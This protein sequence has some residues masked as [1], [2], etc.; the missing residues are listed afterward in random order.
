VELSGA[1]LK[2]A[3]CRTESGGPEDTGC[4][5]LLVPC[6]NPNGATLKL[7]ASRAVG[8]ED[9]VLNGKA[10]YRANKKFRIFAAL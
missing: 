7:I 1:D 9:D 4:R 5:F 3:R 6:S 2:I 10:V 8:S